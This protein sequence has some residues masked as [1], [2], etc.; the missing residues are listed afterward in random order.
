VEAILVVGGLGTRLR[1]LTD[2]LPKSLLPVAGAP[3]V[4]HQI[5]RAHNAGV[6][7]IVLAT[8][9]RAELFA[10]AVGDGSHLGVTV[11]YAVEDEPLGSGGAIRNAATLLVGGADDPVLVFNGDILDDHDMTAQVQQHADTKADATL[12]LTKV[13][14]ARPFGCV[15]TDATGRVTAFLE[16]MAAPPTN[17]INAGCYVFRRAVIDTI[18]VGRAV[19]VERETFP[20]LLTSGATIHGFLDES[21]WRDLGTPESFVQGSVDAVRGLVDAPARPGPP[22]EFLVLDGCEVSPSATLRAGTSV[23][24][25][26]VIG[27]GAVVDGS[28]LLDGAAVGPSAIIRSS[29]VGRNAQIGA[30]AVLD[31]VVVGAGVELPDGAHPEPGTRLS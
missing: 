27:P 16:K 31:G 28:V 4:L 12:Y 11:H 18:P 21:Y 13:S 23:G 9:Y 8:S 20:E 17:Q 15:P 30:D 26:C 22:G 1:P 5:A 10:A 14:D 19:S 2:D 25:G 29:A 6:D 24:A 7:R 3:I